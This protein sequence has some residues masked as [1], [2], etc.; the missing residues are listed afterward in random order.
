MNTIKPIEIYCDGSISEICFILGKE[1]P[2]IVYVRNPYM[3]VTTNEGEYY[4][5]INAIQEAVKKGIKDVIIYSDSQ[6]IVRQLQTDDKGIA[7]Y[8]AREK[9]M[10]ALRNLVWALA[11]GLSS[12]QY[13]WIPREKNPAGIELENR[14]KRATKE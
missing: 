6:L 2:T 8:K 12:V 14:K 9:R 3:K 5:V 11:R 13:V 1:R 4:A 10:L 7:K